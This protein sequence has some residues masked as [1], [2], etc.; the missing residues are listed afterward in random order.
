M[1]APRKPRLIHVP[2][3]VRVSV[4]T[5][6]WQAIYGPEADLEVGVRQY[7]VHLINESQARHEGA[8]VGARRDSR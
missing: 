1:P 8:I 5:E 7:V 6:R 3:K 2:V 4:D